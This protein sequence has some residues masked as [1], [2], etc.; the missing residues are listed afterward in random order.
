M[1]VEAE[2]NHQN[3]AWVW[4]GR[5]PTSFNHIQ[6]YLTFQSLNWDPQGNREV[7]RPK[8]TWNRENSKMKLKKEINKTVSEASTAAASKEKFRYLIRGL[9]STYNKMAMMMI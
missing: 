3:L 1:D 2:L 7:G 9:R 4:Y 6:G 8:S 5:C